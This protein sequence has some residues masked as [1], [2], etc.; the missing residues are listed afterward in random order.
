METET[1]S[2]STHVRRIQSRE[3]PFIS[4]KCGKGFT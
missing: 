3:Q 1:N 4:M 2:E